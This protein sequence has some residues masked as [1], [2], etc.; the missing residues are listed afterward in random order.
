ML[1]LPPPFSFYLV[2]RGTSKLSS[3]SIRLRAMSKLGMSCRD[4]LKILTKK[5]RHT[6]RLF[7]HSHSD[8]QVMQ[9]FVSFL[10]SLQKNREEKVTRYSKNHICDMLVPK[11]EVLINNVCTFFFLGYRKT[12]VL[13]ATSSPICRSLS[14]HNLPD[15]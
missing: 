7:H 12:R 4:P 6:V 2:D 5:K 9:S 3:Q 11:T 8:N 15:K 13:K 1:Q 14:K 10:Q